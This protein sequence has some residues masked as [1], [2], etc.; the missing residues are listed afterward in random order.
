MSAT[1]ASAPAEPPAPPLERGFRRRSLETFATLIVS[2]AVAA[3]YAVLIAR[4]LGPSGKGVL[5]VLFLLPGVAALAAGGAFELANTYF[6]AAR[7]DDRP[8]LA[9]NSWLVAAVGGG[10]AGVLVVGVLAAIGT[11]FGA[12]WPQLVAVCATIPPTI[13]QR[14]LGNLILASGRVRTFNALA[15]VGQVLLLPL[16][17]AGFAVIGKTVNA[18]V[19]AYVASQA[20]TLFATIAAARFGRARPSPPLLQES[21]RYGSVGLLANIVQFFNYRLDFFLL[22]SLASPAAVGVY[23]IAVTIGELLWK[24]PTAASTILFPR[25]ASTREHDPEFTARVS[26]IVV[27]L[28]IAG[29]AAITGISYVLIPLVFG[30]RFSGAFVPLL[31]LLPGIV[32]L[33]LTA[34]ISSHFAGRGE[35]KWST[36]AAVLGLVLTVALCIVL[37]PPYGASGAALASTAAYSITTL[38]MVA[39]FSRRFHVGVADLLMPRRADLSSLRP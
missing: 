5:S 33:G 34:I 3:V 37:I 36:Y 15:V 18:V 35:L 39:V 30:E 17:A 21:F 20:I 24:L 29:G 32:A 6:G 12:T 16:T 11:R 27:A 9:A 1:E 8:R 19:M 25:V 31:L 7:P 23:S 10:L 14:L 4:S 38:A 22:A 26:R 13:A 28:T 2:T